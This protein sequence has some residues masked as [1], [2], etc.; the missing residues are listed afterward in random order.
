MREPEVE[1]AA[2][3]ALSRRRSQVTII[4]RVTMMAENIDV[5]SPMASVTAKPRT[6]PDPNRYSSTAAMK[7]VRLASMMVVK[8]R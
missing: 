4:S 6:G 7:V 3:Q 2:Q 1:S 8:A 5:T